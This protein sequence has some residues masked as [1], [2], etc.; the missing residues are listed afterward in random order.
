MIFNLILN[1]IKYTLN[2]W[3]FLQ[4]NL[5]LNIS[6]TILINCYRVTSI[7]PP[8]MFNEQLFRLQIMITIL[9][10]FLIAS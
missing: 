3:F 2:N 10:L 4:N 1:I 7:F 5:I 6:K 9:V 8:I